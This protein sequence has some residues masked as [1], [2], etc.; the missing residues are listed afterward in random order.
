MGRC[1][2]THSLNPR[3]NILQKRWGGSLEALFESLKSRATLGEFVEGK[4]PKCFG[5]SGFE[6]E[7][8]CKRL[9]CL[10]VATEIFERV[11][12]GK[13]GGK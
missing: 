6:F 2:T 1:V 3:G 4:I 13:A 11:G 12:E 8:M 7:C 10:L 5:V 9:C